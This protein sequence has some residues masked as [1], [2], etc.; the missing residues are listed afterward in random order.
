M[1]ESRENRDIFATTRWTMVMAAGDRES[2]SS[3]AALQSLCSIYWFPLYAYIRRRGYTKEDAEDRTQEFIVGLL[4]REDLSGL[5]RSRGKFRA[6]L[7]ASLKHFLANQHAKSNRQKR[8]GHLTHLSLDWQSADHRFQVVDDQQPSPDLAFDREWAITL[9]EQVLA[10]LRREAEASGTVDRFDA[11]KSY[12]SL[13]KGEM[14]YGQKAAELGW[15]EG[16]VR[17]AV[18]RLRKRYRS[19]LKLEIS[20]TLDDPEMVDEELEVLM[21]SFSG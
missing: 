18:H 21:A 8:G 9:L 1:M 15:E 2:A 3:D 20:K 16:A 4:A 10:K 11:L 6:F 7:L 5:D 13:A 19:M 12:L 17:V 14:S